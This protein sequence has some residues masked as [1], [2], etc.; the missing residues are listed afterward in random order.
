MEKKANKTIFL[1]RNVAPESYGGAE[2]YQLELAD[3]LCRC[4]Y[5]PIII[6]SSRRLLENARAN[7]Y[8]TIE[9]P[10]IKNQNWSGWRNLL[11]PIYMLKQRRRQSWYKKQIAQYQPI[12]MN[13][14]SRDDWIAASLAGKAAGVKIFWTDHADFRSWVLNNI[15]V[16]YKNFIGKFILKIAKSVNRIIMISDFEAEYFKNAAAKYRLN[17]VLVI[18]NG[19]VDKK[20]EYEDEPIANNFCYVGR[21]VKE[22][23]IGELIE[24]FNVF[25]DK[26]QSMTLD[27]YGEGPEFDKYQKLAESNERIIFHGFTDNPIEAIARSEVFILPSYYE[28]LSMSLSQA[29][30]LGKAVIA[31]S[32]GGNSDIIKNHETGI[33]VKSRDVNSLAKAMFEIVENPAK[34][35]QMA[36]NIRQKYEKE[37]DFEKNIK[38]KFIT[39]L[40][41]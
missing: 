35:K 29:A 40:D 7:K 39:L 11:L 31:T 28:G 36:K 10:Y 16:K 30:M 17:N 19:V 9:A 13:I 15:D 41:K 14:Q 34:T 32:E 27:I 2:S 33:L 8:Q 12:A 5:H 25:T 24:A 23:G 20:S 38:E 18:K 1:I 26:N 4:G 3:V 6:T 37:L 21:V 22:K